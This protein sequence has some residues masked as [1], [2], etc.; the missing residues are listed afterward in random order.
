DQL[1]ADLVEL[2]GGPALPAPVVARLHLEPEVAESVLPF[3]V[4]AVER[5][6][7]PADTAL[8]ERDPHVRIPLEDRGADDRRPDVDQV[9]LK[10]GRA[11]EEPGASGEARLLLAPARRHRWEPGEGQRA[12]HAGPPA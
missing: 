8:A 1:G 2:E 9:H 6:G 11:R 4:H 7:D 5:V 12:A 10:P 3:E